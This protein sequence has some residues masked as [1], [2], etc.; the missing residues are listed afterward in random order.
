ME[1]IYLLLKQFKILFYIKYYYMRVCEWFNSSTIQI[2]NFISSP[3]EFYDI[4]TPTNYKNVLSL[5]KESDNNFN[6]K[7]FNEPFINDDKI[8]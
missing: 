1:F 7:L 5:V 3:G 6:L 8:K 4:K 2:Q